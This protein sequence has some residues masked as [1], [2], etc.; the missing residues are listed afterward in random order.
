MIDPC[1]GGK[2]L[3]YE[4]FVQQI[5]HYDL[6]V[7]VVIQICVNGSIGKTRFGKPGFEGLVCKGQILVVLEIVVIQLGAR[8]KTQYL[9]YLTRVVNNFSLLVCHIHHGLSSILIPYVA[10]EPIGYI[11]VFPAIVVKICHEG[12]PTPIRFRDACQLA[13][14]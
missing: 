14:V 10:A 7:T 6:E 9:F 5:I 4:S 12:G 1:F 13:Y 2:I 8:E 11:E 3:K